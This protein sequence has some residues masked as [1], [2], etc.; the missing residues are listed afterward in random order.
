MKSNERTN[1]LHAVRTMHLFAGAGGGILADLLLGHTPVCAVEINSYCWQ[2]LSARQKDGC[3]PWFPIFEDVKTFDGIPWRG[4]IDI[5]C[6][7]FPCTDISAAR[8]NSKKNGKQK[9]LDGES[10]GL[11]RQMRR[12]IREV[13]PR[14]V[15]IEN[16]PLLRKRGL[17]IILRELAVLGYNARW[18]VFSSRQVGADHERARMY[19]VAYANGAQ[20]EGRRVSCRAYQEHADFSRSDWWQSESRLERVANGIPHQMDRLRAIGNA[21]SPIVAASAFR[22]LSEGIE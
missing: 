7:E 16:S 12:I 3:L 10:S 6:G 5:L 2:V 14:I 15:F 8:T 22:I 19:I 4:L 18:G 9:G 20:C 11:W 13:Q 17:N 1:Q 21:Q